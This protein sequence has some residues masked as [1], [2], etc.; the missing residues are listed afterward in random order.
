MI[1]I[2]LFNDILTQTVNKCI[3]GISS[4]VQRNIRVDGRDRDDSR[5]SMM[6]DNAAPSR[7]SQSSVIGSRASSRDSSLTSEFAAARMRDDPNA[8]VSSNQTASSSQQPVAVVAK[9]S[10]SDWLKFNA[11]NLLL[12]SLKNV[13]IE[14]D[15]IDSA[16]RAK[17]SS[18]SLKDL[19]DRKRKVKNE[20]KFYDTTFESAFQRFPNREEKEPMR[21]LYV[22]YK[23][24][25]Q[26]LDAKE[27]NS[28][29]YERLVEELAELKNQRLELKAKLEAYQKEFIKKNSR[30]IR[31]KQDIIEVEEEYNLYHKLKDEIKDL[32]DKIKAC[33]H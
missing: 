24:L 12:H 22:Y 25:K 5:S 1:E 32:E 11:G 7:L 23:Y 20:L 16:E 10:P 13:G 31:F 21:P 4:E 26:A 15:L 29:Q 17:L 19:Q 28:N 30:R 6:S 33:P 3:L 2:D 18:L 14:L 9:S 27:P 8:P